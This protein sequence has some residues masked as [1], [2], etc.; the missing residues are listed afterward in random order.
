ME[1]REVTNAAEEAKVA[2]QC[3]QYLRDVCSWRLINLMLLCYEEVLGMWCRLM[4]PCFAIKSRYGV[5]Q[6]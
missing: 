5:T 4:S 1:Q 6:A 2:I 3:Y